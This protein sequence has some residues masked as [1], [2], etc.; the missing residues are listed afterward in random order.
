MATD[1]D[2]L[3]ICKHCLMRYRNSLFVSKHSLFARHQAVFAS[4]VQRIVFQCIA[5]LVFLSLSASYSTVRSFACWGS[6][7]GR[8]RKFLAFCVPTEEGAAERRF[9]KISQRMVGI[10]MEN[11]Y[12]CVMNYVDIIL[13]LALDGTFTYILPDALLIAA[14]VGKRV[15]VPFRSTQHYVGVITEIHRR[16]PAFACKPIERILDDTPMLQAYQ[17]DLW[18][19]VARYYMCPLGDVLTAALPGGLKATEKY[20]PRMEQYVRLVEAYRTSEGVGV[21]ASMLRRAPM[22]YKLFTHFLQLIGWEYGGEAL[23]TEP[24]VSRE[25]LLNESHLTAPLLQQV[26]KRGILVQVEREVPRLDLRAGSTVEPKPLSEAQTQAYREIRLGLEAK[27]V[28]LLHGVTSSGKTEI[29]IRLIQD[30]IDNG[31]QVLYL[32]P[33]IAL[34]VQ[35]MM[36]LKQVFG[37]RLGIYHSKYSDEERVEIWKKQMSDQPFDVIL[38]ARSAVLLPFSRLG[39]VVVDEEHEASYKQQDPAPRYHARSV[40]VMMAHMLGAKTLLGSATPSI[41]SYHNAQIGKYALVRLEQRY[42]GVQ[43]P[44]VETVDV[45]DLRHRKLM[46]GPLSPM[47]LSAMRKALEQQEQV[48]LFQNRRGFARQFEC[49][50]CGWTPRCENCDV[51]LTYHKTDGRLTCHYCGFSV[52][53]PQECPACHE[54]KLRSKG[55]GTERIEDLVREEFPEAKVVRMD[56]DSTRSKNAYARIINDFSAGKT[57]VLIGTQMVTKGLDFAGVSVVGI[58]DA[59]AILN[60]PDYQAYEQAYQMLCQVSGR[61]GRRNTR[62]RVLLQTRQ[63][64]LSVVRQVVEHDYEAFYRDVAQERTDFHYPPFYHLIYIY[65]KHTDGAV[66]DMAAQALAQRLRSRLG[67]RLLGPDR[68]FV[69]RVKRQ[70]IRQMM[71]KLEQ[72]IALGQCKDFILQQW[73]SVMQDKRF[74]GL[75]VYF[76][77]DPM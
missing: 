9:G 51:S 31:Q 48:I 17:L 39:L 52:S 19:W 62:G 72:G 4:E 64:Q 55:F 50:T 12:L 26:I 5:Y 71:L 36:R 43:L 40:A 23:T 32:V 46:R 53:L 8:T 3:F 7:S 30:A 16:T 57:Q 54:T 25:E 1:L 21:A 33:E 69:S 24:E 60:Y 63:P 70:E 27:D 65:M 35:M 67:T 59:D 41:A 34:T 76:D 47:L 20:K 15:L 56:L 75:Q 22:Q 45:Q 77:V 44:E 73:K 68:P 28:V 38:G 42:A 61:A 14:A 11:D 37:A 58:L 10:A 29:Y 74:S 49:P 6:L 2:I 66:C 18:A 13:P